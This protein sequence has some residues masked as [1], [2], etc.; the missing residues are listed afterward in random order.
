MADPVVCSG[1]MASAFLEGVVTEG[2][3]E[4]EGVQ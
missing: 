4:M 3:V 1:G 2:L